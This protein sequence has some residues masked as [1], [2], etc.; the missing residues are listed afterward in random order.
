VVRDFHDRLSPAG[1]DQAIGCDMLAA[2]RVWNI[3]LER[4]R[5]WLIPMLA[6]LVALGSLF[7]ISAGGRF[8]PM[9]YP[10]F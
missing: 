6:M 1:P 2:K 8:V 7:L 5:Y 10:M 9:I 4:R 3:L